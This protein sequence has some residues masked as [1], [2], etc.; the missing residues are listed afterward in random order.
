[1]QSEDFPAVMKSKEKEV[2][3][4]TI[5]TMSQVVLYHH[6][7]WW[8]LLKLEHVSDRMKKTAQLL[9]LSDC[10]DIYLEQAGDG[11]GMEAFFTYL[12]QER[13]RMFSGERLCKSQ[14][15]VR[16]VFCGAIMDSVQ[17]IALPVLKNHQEM[18]AHYTCML[19]RMEKYEDGL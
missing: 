6:T 8:M 5:T 1:M 17:E 3:I 14:S 4:C 2:S 9:S 10:L 18:Q 19:S 13:D 12:E 7:P 11:K 16:E 15:V